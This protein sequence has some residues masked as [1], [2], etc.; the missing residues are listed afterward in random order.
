MSLTLAPGEQALTQPD[1]HALS[2]CMRTLRSVRQFLPADV[3]QDSI[4]FV[5]Q[6]AVW[7]GS[8]KNRQPWRFIVVRDRNTMSA[9]GDW[10]RRGWQRM[11]RHVNRFPDAQTASEEHRAQMRD[12][13]LL[14]DTFDKTPVVIVPCFVPILRNPA[15]FYGGASIYPA[16]QNLLLAARAIG[17]GATLTTL[18]SLD[19]LPGQ[20][21]QCLTDQLRTI[22]D[23]PGDVA[24]AA[25]IPLGWPAVAITGVRRLPVPAVTYAESWGR[26]WTRTP[27]LVG[28]S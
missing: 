11:V 24:P 27:R 16:I 7:A 12:G 5:L 6:H 19:A 14:A 3:D 17:L 4:D 23:I 8:A 26:P 2:H 18:L 15:N 20:N 28:T 13:M 21:Q 9:L 10:Y 1:I 25:V 22:L